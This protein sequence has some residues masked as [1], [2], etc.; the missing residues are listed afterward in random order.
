VNI[1]SSYKGLTAF[2]ISFG[3][4]LVADLA[5]PDIAAALPDGALKW[6]TLIGAPAVV[7]LGTWLKRNEPTVEEAEAALVRARARA[8]TG[9]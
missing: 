4:L 1:K 2:V 7:G 8:T 5:D 9:A 6:L 3:G